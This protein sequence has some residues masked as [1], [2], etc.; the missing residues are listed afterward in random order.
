MDKTL[1]SALIGAVSGALVAGV[2][3]FVVHALSLRRELRIRHDAAARDHIE[4]QI[5][6]FYGPLLGL[7]L[8][9][10]LAFE[11][12]SR[13]LPRDQHG[14][15]EFSRFSDRDGEIWRFFVEEYFL[16]VNAKIRDLIR[17]NMHLLEAGILPKTFATF[18]EHEVQFEALHHLWKEK[19]VESSS[20]PSLGWPVEFE[21]DV[22]AMLDELSFRHQS[23][24]R[25]LGAA[26][27]RN[28]T[29]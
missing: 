3:W 20:I 24:L 11:M 21:N 22:Q 19:G 18:L 16:P 29:S 4:K 17:S 7:I 5:E 10:R 12:A 14:Q 27:G 2:G 23:F 8:Q 13:I 6:H 25:R 28:S 9:A 15:I 1:M 26:A